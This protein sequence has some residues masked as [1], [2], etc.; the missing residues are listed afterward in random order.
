M[1]V[2][3]L[4]DRSPAINAQQSPG[5]GPSLRLITGRPRTWLRYVRAAMRYRAA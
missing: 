5:G 3:S 1:P 4:L 2:S